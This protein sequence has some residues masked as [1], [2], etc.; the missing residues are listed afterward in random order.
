MTRKEVQAS[1]AEYLV[2]QTLHRDELMAVLA[3]WTSGPTPPRA[4]Y[5][6]AEMVD[7]ESKIE[8]LISQL[9]KAKEQS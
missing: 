4:R 7:I 8:Q 1:I 5:L 2:T 9:P 3:A 6:F